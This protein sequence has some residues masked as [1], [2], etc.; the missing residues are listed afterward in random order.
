MEQPT[1][2]DTNDFLE[3]ANREIRK[4]QPIL[5]LANN[6]FEF[7][8]SDVCQYIEISNR[9]PYLN[10]VIRFNDK[11]VLDFKKGKLDMSC[12]LHEMCH[13]LTNPLY[14]KGR[15]R[16]TTDTELDDE[17]ELLT[18]TIACIINRLKG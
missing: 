3:W 1:Q 17:R 5:G 6:S 12:M 15:K 8:H 11:A 10:H 14:L 4:W 9:Y 13:V 18:D 7:E 16:F 2:Q